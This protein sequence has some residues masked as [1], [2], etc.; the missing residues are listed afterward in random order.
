MA[1]LPDRCKE[2]VQGFLACIPERLKV[3]ITR[4]CTDM[5]DGFI[6]AAREVLPH[7]RVVVD[8]LHVAKA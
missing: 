6:N 8:R 7:A 4:V 2:T 3:T 1:V 5:Y